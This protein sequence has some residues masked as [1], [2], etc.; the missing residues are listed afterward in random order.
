V[1]EEKAVSGVQPKNLI[2]NFRAPNL[3]HYQRWKEYVQ[4]AK[5]NGMDVCHITLSLVDSFMKG[6]EGAAE[7]RSGKQ[8]INIQQTNVFQ[9]QVGKP[10]REPYDLSCVKKEY[11]RTFS[12]I[13]LEAYILHKASDLKREFSYQ[14]FLELKHDAFRRIILRLRRKG[15]IVANPQRT[16]PR[17]YYLTDRLADNASERGT[18]Q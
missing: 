2:C 15:K 5:D 13:L 10:R 7:V 8:V 1:E 3:R 16:V 14:D 17:F 12:S 18:I 11:Q 9:Y 4:W 6:T